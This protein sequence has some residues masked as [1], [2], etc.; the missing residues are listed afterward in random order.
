MSSSADMERV[1][2][3]PRRLRR[4]IVVLAIYVGLLA[5]G[6]YVARTWSDLSTLGAEPSDIE[7]L[8]RAMLIQ[9]IA[10]ILLVFVI[11]SAL[12]FV[13]G[14]EIG[15]GLMIVFG[16]SVAPFVYL[17]MV[18][19][20]S[21]AYLIG[22]LLPAQWMIDL[23]SYLGFQ[24]AASLVEDFCA[25]PRDRRIEHLVA[26]AP[27]R[28]VPFLLRN[29]YLAVM[30]MLNIPG[31]SVIGGGGGIALAAGVSGLFRFPIFLLA[32]LVA[33]APLPIIFLLM[34]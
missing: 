4:R 1:E 19:A 8:D 18:L 17:A 25:T 24:R 31:N 21:L 13:P 23:F 26:A 12:P 10:V 11:T 7:T 27:P 5:L 15:L 32:I 33:V 3:D 6:W 28:I 9:L 34:G 22:R 20:L 29:R 2:K 30:L 14:A 16:G